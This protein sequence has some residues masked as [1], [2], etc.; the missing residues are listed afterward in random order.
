MRKDSQLSEEVIRIL[1]WAVK[2]LKKLVF[3]LYAFFFN[4]RA[5]SAPDNSLIGLVSMHNANFTDSLFEVEQVL[6]SR[7]IYSFLKISREDLKN[8]FKALKFCTVSAY[9][10]GGAKYIFLN[11]NFMPLAKLKL[12]PE[13]KVIQLWH[14]Q[15]VFKKFG[16]SI[17]RPPEIRQREIAANEKLSYVVCS[18]CG[19]AKYY[20]EA[21]GVPIEKVI[22]SGTPNQDYYFSHHDK[23]EIRARFNERY[24][25]ATGKLLVLYAPTFR[26]SKADDAEILAHM[27]FKALKDSFEYPIEILVRLHPQVRSSVGDFDSL[28]YVVD[29][30]DYENI[31][32]LCLISDLL[33]TDYSSVCMDFSLLNKPMVFYAY[34][35]DAY[36]ASRD[37]YFDYESYVPG[38]VARNM[39][40][41]CSIIKSGNFEDDKAAQFKFINFGTP[42]GDATVSLLDKLGL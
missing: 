32:E 30:T 20:A 4:L 2:Y 12:N 38:P 37:F 33:I 28:P 25:S 7:G 16:L 11:D 42:L 31:N 8:P 22:D 1:E 35:L 29:V 26:E 40:E 6:L 34:D 18:S 10:L 13:T 27:D 5:K 24:P 36:T 14:G 19:I 23:A 39:D 17:E 15:G 9:K 41:L 21:F 3:L